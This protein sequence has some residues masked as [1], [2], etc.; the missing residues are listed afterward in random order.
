MFHSIT[1]LP[2]LL[3]P[4]AYYSA[5]AH[6]LD[7]AALR[8]T[9]QL[10]GT[11]DQLAQPGDFLTADLLDTPIIVRNADGKLRAFLNVCAH[12][13]CL[14][15]SLPRGNAPRLRCQ[16]HGWEYDHE[17]CAAKIPSPKN[18]PPL[19]KG[20]LRL[21]EL[22][23]EQAGQLVFV[24]L[25]DTGPTL[26]E[27]CGESYPVICGRFGSDFRLAFDWRPLYEANWK[28]P[29]ENSL[30]AYHV[31][32]V[33]PET[34]REDPGEQRSEHSFTP[35]GSLFE[36]DMPFSVHSRID[37]LLQQTQGWVMRRLGIQ[38]QNRYTL[39]HVYPNL[40]FSFTD[41]V[42]FCQAL[43]P[44]SP[45]SC[46]ATVLQYSPRGAGVA[47]PRRILAHAWGALAAKITRTILE[48][49]RRLFADIQRGVKSA[50]DPGLLGRCEE[51]LHAF[52]KYMLPNYHGLELL[53]D[54]CRRD[55]SSPESTHD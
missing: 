1:R 28:I 14:L 45:T 30:E 38:P 23:L 25:S 51:R 11:A 49:D 44:A 18:F 17:G 40:L 7:V 54:T 29:V 27:Q 31:P 10:V 42:S 9:W 3:P 16:Y 53:S 33:H 19:V 39:Y 47:W 22:A 15:T 50:R 34:F 41:S 4:A 35:T 52:Q 55:A 8:Q 6:A 13:H 32:T 37:A 48:E 21:H 5:Q 36:V 43:L 24:R 46:Q 2:Q 20:E 12:R 26:A